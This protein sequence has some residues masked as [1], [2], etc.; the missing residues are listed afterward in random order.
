M[1]WHVFPNLGFDRILWTEISDGRS[2]PWKFVWTAAP[3]YTFPCMLTTKNQIANSVCP[4]DMPRIHFERR[5]S[6]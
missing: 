2:T 3:A 6:P 5:R 4:L 1:D